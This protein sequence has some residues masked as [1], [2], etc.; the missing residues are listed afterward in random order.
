[1]KLIPAGTFTLGDVYDA[2]EVTLTQPFYLGVTEVTN[3]QWQAVMGS[4]PTRSYWTDADQPV[5]GVNWEDTVAFCKKLSA[6]P[7]ERAAGRV[8]RLPTEAEWEYACRAGSTTLDSHDGSGM[9]LELGWS[10]SR[11]GN[12]QTHPVGQKRPNAWARMTCMG[13]SRN[14]AATGTVIIQVVRRRIRGDRQQAQNGSSGGGAAVVTECWSAYGSGG[15][16][17]LMASTTWA[18]AFP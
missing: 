6:E 3:A 7:D 11:D 10:V 18:S 9:N 14:G 2:H 5:D 8:Y 4:L 15:V 12:E 17:P 1:M 13:M 16:G